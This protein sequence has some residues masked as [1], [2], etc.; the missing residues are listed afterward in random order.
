MTFPFSYYL[1]TAPYTLV[2]QL[3]TLFRKKKQVVFY[4][5][6]YLDYV[7]FENVREYL[8]QM[9]IVAK[10]KKVKAELA[11]HGVDADLWPA[12]PNVVIMARHAF[13]KFPSHKIIKLGL[14][15]GAY[16][17]KNFIRAEKYNVFDLFLFTSEYEVKEAEAFGIT[18]GQ[19]GGFPKID[20]FWL[21][22]VDKKVEKL[23]KELKFNNRKPNILFSATWE[24]SG[25]S[26]IDKW[27]DKLGELTDDFNVMVTLHPFCNKTYSDTIRNTPGV[28]F[29]EDT[30]NYLYLKLADLMVGDTSS[31]IAEFCTLDKPMVTFKVK[32]SR[33]LMPDIVKLIEEV[34][35][36]IDEYNELKTSIK[37][38]LSNP[39]E[40]SYQRQKYNKI[41]FEDLNV[42]HGKI[43]AAKIQKIL[44]QVLN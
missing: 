15:H 9:R 32:E 6:C 12:F 3:V 8:P 25:M 36:P 37:Y 19:S 17:F 44:D 43:A 10:N 31:I 5:D 28:H 13:H 29:I 4:S 23:K 35:Y 11:Q 39:Y 24:N 38:A 26:A 7:I 14:N 18:C 41:M 21:D 33:R 30:K 27:F 16:H 2:W 42:K 34:S 20:S 40:K 22:G 1:L